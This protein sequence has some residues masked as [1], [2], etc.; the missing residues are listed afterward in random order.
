MAYVASYG[1]SWGKLYATGQVQQSACRYV[2]AASE[3]VPSPCRRPSLMPL[4]GD[5]EYRTMWRGMQE[6]TAI[7]Q[8]DRTL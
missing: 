7:P 4:S 8:P 5:V 3:S 1:A 6:A 2:V